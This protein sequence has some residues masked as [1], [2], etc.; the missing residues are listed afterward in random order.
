MTAGAR[1]RVCG[2]PLSRDEIGLTKKTIS[3]GASEYFCLA[4]LADH[5]QVSQQQLREKIVQFREMG[6]LLFAPPGAEE[7]QS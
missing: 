6:C 1:C 3:R 7:Q 4:C 2:A 5:F